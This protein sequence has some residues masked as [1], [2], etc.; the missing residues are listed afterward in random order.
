M[1]PHCQH[2]LC[3]DCPETQDAKGL[4]LS[5]CKCGVHAR[6]LNWATQMFI[7]YPDTIPT[8]FGKRPT[9]NA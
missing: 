9:A 1:C 6:A 5:C 4:I 3:N 2:A 7:H 8:L